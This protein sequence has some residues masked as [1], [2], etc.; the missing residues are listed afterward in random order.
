MVWTWLLR[1]TGLSIEAGSRRKS[2]AYGDFKCRLLYC[3]K[4]KF[5]KKKISFSNVYRQPRD[6]LS[7]S[8]GMKS[9]CLPWAKYSSH[10]F[11]SL[12]G[13]LFKVRMHRFFSKITRETFRWS[14]NDNNRDVPM[15]INSLAFFWRLKREDNQIGWQSYVME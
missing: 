5:K 9:Q 6:V 3:Q 1:V 15:V 4:Y 10:E 7:Q 11:R 8:R 13:C 14:L 12:I 2:A